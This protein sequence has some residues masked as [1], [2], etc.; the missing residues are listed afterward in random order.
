MS[1]SSRP[2]GIFTDR[3]THWRRRTSP[4]CTKLQRPTLTQG[5]FL[6]KHAP[7]IGCSLRSWSPPPSRIQIAER[8][9]HF[10]QR[11]PFC[12]API[13][14]ERLHLSLVHVFAGDALPE[15]VIGFSRIVGNAIRFDQFSL[16]LT[17]ALTYRNSG[18]KKP[19]VLATGPA[20]ERVSR[21]A[22]Q[23]GRAQSFLSRN[24]KGTRGSISPHVT[25][26][27]DK[28]VIPKQQIA[29][30]IIPVQEVALVHSHSG[31]SRYDILGRWP[32]VP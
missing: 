12:S 26:I 3:S 18:K 24:H 19:F 27:R 15:A 8:F 11:H 25:L 14:P 16:T 2:A 9:T 10:Q 17:S 23:I 6:I 22:A 7:D 21:L 31:Q 13:R 29:P 1:A 28:A 4:S 5:A 20:S 32:L 30:V